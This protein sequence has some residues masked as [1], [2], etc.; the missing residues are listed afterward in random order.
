MISKIYSFRSFLFL[1]FGAGEF[2]GTYENSET[3][4]VTI[5]AQLPHG[6]ITISYVV[7]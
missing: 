5:V 7:A 1:N 4:A 6:F 3:T 2:S